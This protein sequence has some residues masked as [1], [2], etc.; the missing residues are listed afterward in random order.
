MR[1]HKSLRL[2]VALLTLALLAPA[3][4][5]R[6][7]DAAEGARS[8]AALQDE[9]EREDDEGDK[10]GQ[11][12]CRNA[13]KRAGKGRGL[14]PRCELGSSSGIAKGDFNG[15]G[16]GDLAVGVPHEGIDGKSSAGAVNV[17]YGSPDGLTAAGNQFWHQ[18]SLGVLDVAEAPD[19][20]GRSLAAGDFN[21]DNLSD[22]AVGVPGEDVG[23]V[24]D[25][26]AVHVLYG[27]P[28]GLSASGNQLW[29]QDSSG[30][31]DTAEAEDFFGRSLAWGDYNGDGVGDLA[32]GVP[33]EDVGSV[34]DAGAV[35]V[36]Y[37]TRA[38]L[39]A[40]GGQLWTQNTSGVPD[41]AEDS[42]AFGRS[43]SAGDF[44]GDSLS[45]LAVGVP[46]EDVGSVLDAGAVNVIYAT[47][48]GLSAGGSQFWSQG[49][50]GIPETAEEDDRFGSALAAGD[51]NGDGFS[52]LAVGAPS[53]DVLLW[54]DTGAVNVITG[55]SGGLSALLSQVWHQDSPGVPDV[56]DRGDAFGSALAAGD[57]NG[58]GRRD[59]AVGAP[60]ED[61]GDGGPYEFDTE[62][63]AV[64]VIYGSPSLL[65]A[66]PD[67]LYGI[68]AARFF[69][70]GAL[71][72][73]DSADKGE[74]FGSA[75]TA[76]DFNGDQRSDLAIGVPAQYVRGLFAAGAVHVLYGG[77]FSVGLSGPGQVWTQDTPNILDQAEEGDYLG[78]S[79]Y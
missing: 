39:S 78:L 2:V 47:A 28:G 4:P 26:G 13:L 22:L 72:L 40:S 66:S 43:L 42:D 45:D 73:A 8:P 46:L 57:F 12:P 50:L 49:S 9:G 1:H 17:I 20:F 24:L 77:G 16:F 34:A 74:I 62:A 25:A 18:N 37:G 11:D 68:P 14:S 69:A 33:S 29:T 36:L 54:D 52:E 67:Q 59:L 6:T 71:G 75:L 15:D 35:H 7:G 58:D 53:E 64:T 19:Q 70:Q 27:T 48:T 63:G 5:A 32:V 60:F 76:W 55:T 65:D 38:G 21:G 56:A 10:G 61:L 51:F 30:V 79:L 23:S 44:N 41:A 3:F 31:P